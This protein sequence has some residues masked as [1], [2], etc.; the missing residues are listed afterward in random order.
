MDT[1]GKQYL[2]RGIAIVWKVLQCTGT[3]MD[4]EK[5]YF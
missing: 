2:L 3:V 4:Y 1:S 5:Y